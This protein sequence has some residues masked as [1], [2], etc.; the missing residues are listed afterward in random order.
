[1][2]PY[3]IIDRPERDEL[4][5]GPVWDVQAQA[6]YWVDIVNRRVFRLDPGTGE[7]IRWRTPSMVSLAVP[8]VRGDLLITLADGA[9]RLAKEHVSIVLDNVHDR[10]N[11]HASHNAAVRT[12]GLLWTTLVSFNDLRNPI[13]MKHLHQAVVVRFLK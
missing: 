10:R 1:M 6:L 5:E 11:Y 3:E 7:V 9:H 12:I 2:T 13:R 8:T 4:G